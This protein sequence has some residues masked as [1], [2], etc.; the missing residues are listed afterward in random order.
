MIALS[1]RVS[2]SSRV[3]DRPGPGPGIAAPRPNL[4]SRYGIADQA[5]WPAG[6]RGASINPQPAGDPAAAVRGA[7]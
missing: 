3:L 4:L 1:A 6:W 2:Q 5:G 7:A